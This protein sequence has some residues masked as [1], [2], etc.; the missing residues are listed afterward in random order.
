[1]VR[2]VFHSSASLRSS[3]IDKKT[4]QPAMHVEAIQ[5]FLEVIGTP[6][7]EV[8]DERTAN[9][10]YHIDANL[11]QVWMEYSFY[12]DGTLLHCGVNSIQLMRLEDGWK[13]TDI[14]DTRRR[15]PCAEL[16]VK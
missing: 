8:Y 15:E 14:A 6:H 5:G 11:A 4:G 3:F 1:M 10:V 7:T 13:I 9:Y 16:P 2:K 12:L